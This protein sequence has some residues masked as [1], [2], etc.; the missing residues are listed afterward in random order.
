MA[1]PLRVEYP[2]AFYHVINRGNAGGDIFKS[3]RDREK[4]LEYLEAATS[5]FSIRI[6]TYCLMTNHYHLL[7][8]TPVANLSRAIQWLNVSYAV[9]SLL[10]KNGFA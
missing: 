8:E 1:R 7:V 4:F 6:H 3:L 5:R 10:S 2:G 9:Y